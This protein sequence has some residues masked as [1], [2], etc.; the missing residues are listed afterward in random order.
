MPVPRRSNRRSD[1]RATLNKRLATIQ[2]AI[3]R[4]RRTRASVRRAEFVAL[5]KSLR[6][7]ELNSERIAKQSDE[8]AVQ[9]T[10]IAH[11]QAQVDAITRSLRKA[12]LLTE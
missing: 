2:T 12:K 1:A 7:V 11:L 8:L 5:T 3:E 9:F 6:Q 4:M 10:R